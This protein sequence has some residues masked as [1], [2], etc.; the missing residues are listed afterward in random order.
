MKRT[1]SVPLINRLLLSLLLIVAGVVHEANGQ[2]NNTLTLDQAI[3]TALKNNREAKN[4]RLE[5]EKADD[6]LDAYRTRRLPSFKINSLVSQPLNSI[7]TTFERGIFGI[8]PSNVPVPIEDTVIKSGTNTNFLFVGQVT[9]PLTQLR[10]INLQRVEC[11]HVFH[12]A[13]GPGDL[14]DLRSRFETGEVGKLWLCKE[15]TCARG[16]GFAARCEAGLCPAVG[17]LLKVRGYAPGAAFGPETW[18]PSPNRGH[19]PV[20]K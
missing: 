13:V 3:A 10:R 18:G 11:R 17:D 16:N 2:D 6:K 1:Y 14:L 19:S 5:I 8:Y 9:Q 20:L 4:A 15:I 7:D 12:V